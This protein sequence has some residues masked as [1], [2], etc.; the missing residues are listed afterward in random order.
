MVASWRLPLGMP[1]LSL[2]A[3]RGLRFDACYGERLGEATHRAFVAHQSIAF[4]DNAKQQRVVVA[5]GRG[6]DNAQPVAAGLALHPQL[7]ARA[8]PEGY[9]SA[10]QRLGIADGI[11]KTQHQHFAGARI[12]HD[13]R[14]EAIHLVEIDFGFAAHFLPV[15][16]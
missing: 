3:T 12:L 16:A 11:Q 14:Y 4:D 13:A 15:S 2:L 1:S 5:V 8:A 10:L 7:L 6:R 9:K